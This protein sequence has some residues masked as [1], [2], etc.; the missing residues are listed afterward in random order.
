MLNNMKVDSAITI[1]QQFCEM[2]TGL[3]TLHDV[4]KIQVKLV[5]KPFSLSTAKTSLCLSVIKLSKNLMTYKFKCT[6]MVVVNKKNGGVR[7]YVDLKRLNCYVLREHYPL[8]K[9]DEVL[10]QLTKTTTFTKLDGFWQVP[11]S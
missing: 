6:G 5:T 7:I 9:V 8:S 3:G 1:K 4:F 2:F 11:L 10:A